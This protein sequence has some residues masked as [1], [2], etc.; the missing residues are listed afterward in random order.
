MTTLFTTALSALGI[1][2][3][4]DGGKGEDCDAGCSEGFGASVD[5]DSAVSPGRPRFLKNCG[6]ERLAVARLRLARKST[7]GLRYGARVAA[8]T[9]DAEV[10][11]LA[12]AGVVPLSRLLENG[13]RADVPKRPRPT[14]RLVVG[15]AVV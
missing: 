14:K 2:D 1:G 8:G 6:L 11:E 7:A 4:T 13:G 15:E 3:G 12:G 5:D 10:D 9:A